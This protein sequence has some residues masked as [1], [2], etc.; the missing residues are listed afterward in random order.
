MRTLLADLERCPN[1][2]GELKIIVATS[3]VKQIVDNNVEHL[4]NGVKPPREAMSKRV[5]VAAAC[6]LSIS[7]AQ[8]QQYPAKPV[9]IINPFAPGG[10]T[11]IAKKNE[12]AAFQR[13]ELAKWGNIVRDSGAKVD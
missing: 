5:L 2:G 4:H 8:A 11:D 7:M 10:A 9:R 1:C 6:V 3:I 12:L 13:A